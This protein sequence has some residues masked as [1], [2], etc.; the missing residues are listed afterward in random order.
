MFAEQHI[1]SILLMEMNFGEFLTI[2]VCSIIANNMHCSSGGGI[3]PPLS[4]MVTYTF[5]NGTNE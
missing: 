2:L 4:K 1:H 5:G 3:I